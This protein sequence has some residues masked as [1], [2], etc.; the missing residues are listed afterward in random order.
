M[1][2]RVRAAVM[3]FKEERLLLVKHVDPHTANEWWIPPGG[4]L[5][6]QD[7]SIIDCAVREVYE[8]TGLEIR[9]G[10]LIYL[11]EFLESNPAVHHIEL[12]FLA[13]GFNGELTME[14][15]HGKGPDE[16]LIQ[17]LEWF[18]RDELQDLTVYP[19]MLRDEFWGDYAAG[20]PAVRHLGVHTDSYPR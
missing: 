8:E 20:F 3:I 7:R 4:G 13:E 15:I 17:E 12:F 2:H 11:R 1:E 16:D 14:N 5:E 18:A 19:E 9:V 6:V 10:R